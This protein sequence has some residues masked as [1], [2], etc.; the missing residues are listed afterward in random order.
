MW[1]AN[2]KL[3][4]GN[5]ESRFMLPILFFLLI[6]AA[7]IPLIYLYLRREQAK[8]APRNM[9]DDEWDRVFRI[10]NKGEIERQKITLYAMMVIALVCSLLVR[11]LAVGWI[12]IFFG[13]IFVIA[14]LFIHLF[15]HLAV[16]I[17]SKGTKWIL[18]TMVS[19]SHTMLFLCLLTQSDA[20]DGGDYSGLTRMLSWIDIQLSSTDADKTFNSSYTFAIFLVLSWIA[21]HLPWLYQ[22]RETPKLSE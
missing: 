6:A 11:L 18:L 2:P 13:I 15:V 10:N 20:V 5:Q 22:T 19:F 9:Y 17:R 4:V 3:N 14:T 12:F 1:M 16:I 8:F 21:V 7:M